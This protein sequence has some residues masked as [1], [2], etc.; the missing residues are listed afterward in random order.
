MLT[1]TYNLSH[2]NTLP[3][4]T[5]DISL[6]Y[7]HIHSLTVICIFGLIILVGIVVFGFLEWRTNDVEFL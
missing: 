7:T 3:M 5:F 2:L 4:T 1:R 6:Y